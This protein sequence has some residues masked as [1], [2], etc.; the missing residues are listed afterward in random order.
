MTA[1]TDVARRVAERSA[2]SYSFDRYMSWVGVARAVLMLGFTERETEAILRSKWTRWAADASEKSYGFATGP[3]LV[4]WM[5]KQYP[6]PERLQ[7]E[8]RTLTLE[9]FGPTVYERPR[10]ITVTQFDDTVKMDDGDVVV[11][12]KCSGTLHAEVIAMALRDGIAKFDTR[13]L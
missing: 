10:A 12:M 4:R 13:P 8:V 7:A 11:E 1:T 9:T 6:K 5:N 2:D 3:D